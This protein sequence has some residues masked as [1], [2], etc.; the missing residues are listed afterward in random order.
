[1]L[2]LIG[3]FSLFWLVFFCFFLTFLFR[4]VHFYYFF[5]IFKKFDICM[6]SWNGMPFLFEENFFFCFSRQ[7]AEIC[8]NNLNELKF[9]EVSR[10]SFSDRCWKLIFWEGFGV[11]IVEFPFSWI[12]IYNILIITIGHNFGTDDYKNTLLML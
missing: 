1:M 12:P 8:P 2:F 7:K 3:I 11:T 10:N 4:M 6:R 9:C 5:M